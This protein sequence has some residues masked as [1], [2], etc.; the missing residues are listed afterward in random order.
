M[1]INPMT[2]QQR[3]YTAYSFGVRSRETDFSVAGILSET[4]VRA[5][6]IYKRRKDWSVDPC[7]SVRMSLHIKKKVLLV[8]MLVHLTVYKP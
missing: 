4:L 6:A 5:S 3:L 8:K 7:I 2:Q 1:N